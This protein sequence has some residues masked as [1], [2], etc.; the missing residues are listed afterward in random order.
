[1]TFEL[2]YLQG[3]LN[4]LMSQLRMQTQVPGA[5]ADQHCALDPMLLDEIRQVRQ[6]TFLLSLG[7]IH[8]VQILCG[9]GGGGVGFPYGA[10]WSCVL[11]LEYYLVS[12]IF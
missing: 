2:A 10:L 3:R 5:R 9:I 7:V 4:E 8:T 12:T 1:M 6:F 11:A